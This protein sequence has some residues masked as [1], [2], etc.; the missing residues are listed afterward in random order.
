MNWEKCLGFW[1]GEW[2]LTPAVCA[3]VAWVTTPV[4][5]LGVP[6]ECYRDPEPYWQKQVEEVRDKA[7]KWKS[8]HLS[9]FARATVC[10]LFLIS[11]I[12]YVMQVLHCSRLNVQKLHRVFAVFIW[13]SKWERCRRT[14]LFRRVKMGGLGL[15]HL[16]MRQVVNRF[17]FLR[18]IKDP[19]LRTVCQVRL[20]R[21]V[22]E[23]IV[24]TE[25][26]NGRIFGFLKEVVFSV[27]FLTAR[28]SKEYLSDVR[29][30]Q[31]YRDICDSVFPEPMYRALYSGG[32][33]SNVLKRVKKMRVPPGTKNFFFKLHTGTL[34]VKSFQEATGFFL[35]WGSHC[36][37]CK[38]PETIDHVFLHCWEG[39][40]F[41][42]VLQRTIKKE[43]PLDPHGIRFL[44]TDNED[45]I[46]CDVV[47]LTGLHS[48]W[49]SRMA[50]YHC[51]PDARPA[52]MYFREAMHK[53]IEVH[54][55]E[56]SAP[57]WLS[58]LEPLTDL[59][60]F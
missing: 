20:G 23:F 12:W 50:G 33:G 51:D 10:N 57:E 8:A 45:G 25:H 11:K 29:R 2:P 59:R 56:T 41:W 4:K 22:P 13:A 42:D 40:Y 17:L 9:V 6:L 52:R 24:A 3:N 49:R 53:F 5:Y 15:G 19:F 43:L 47:M 16:F 48:I 44:P 37:I 36:L 21:S 30:K 39:V 34:P 58:R 1:H 28:F 14:N 38:Q 7:D 31:L 55:M 32:P 27:R 60:E 18:D 54:K 46:P 35:P 26:M